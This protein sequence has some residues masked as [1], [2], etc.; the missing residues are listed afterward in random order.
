MA[1]LVAQPRI[2]VLIDGENFPA[3]NAEAL[4]KAIGTWGEPA[5]RR[6][7][8]DPEDPRMKAWVS[9]AKAHNI[10]FGASQGYTK[11]KNSSDI[12]L[13]VDAMDLLLTRRLA[14]FCLVT[15]DSDFT[16]L[17]Y[18]VREHGLRI[19]GVG[20][21]KAAEG[22]RAHYDD[23]RVLDAPKPKAKNKP[24]AIAPKQVPPPPALPLEVESAIGFV[25]GK[26]GWSKVKS[27]ENRLK[28]Q[29][30]L[31]KVTDHGAA[32]LQ[33]LLR[34]VPILEFDPSHGVIKQVRFKA[35]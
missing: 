6:V 13:C 31:F 2:A 1:L 9:A 24:K 28:T 23:F 15:S 8:G 18:R 16:H 21:S 20:E 22:F 12:A 17:V 26:K 34:Q 30:P 25:A 14:G 11:A 35:L 32:N 27:V 7:Y 5:I 19:Y 4:F 10:A 33:D 29:S 3:A